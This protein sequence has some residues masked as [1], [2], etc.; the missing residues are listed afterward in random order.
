MYSVGEIT[1]R[2]FKLSLNKK[3]RELK[4]ARDAHSCH[5]TNIEPLAPSLSDLLRAMVVMHNNNGC[6]ALETN[7]RENNIKIERP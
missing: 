1:S 7:N 2:A 6:V 3:L 5:I 4:P